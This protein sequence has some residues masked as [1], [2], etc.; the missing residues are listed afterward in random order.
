MSPTH[1]LPLLTMKL[2]VPSSADEIHSAL[3]VRLFITSPSGTVKSFFF[4]TN[5]AFQAKVPRVN[6]YWLLLILTHRV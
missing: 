6:D 5:F 1:S 3:S 2:L 4:H